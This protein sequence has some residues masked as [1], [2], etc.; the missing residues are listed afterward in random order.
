MAGLRRLL[1]LASSDPENRWDYGR[2]MGGL[3]VV[4]RWFIDHAMASDVRVVKSPQRATTIRIS[5]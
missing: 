4:V 3:R 1:I 2:V 5:S